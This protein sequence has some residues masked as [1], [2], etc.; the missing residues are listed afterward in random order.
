MKKRAGEIDNDNLLR[1][2]SHGSNY[3]LDIFTCI[4]DRIET[5][6]AIVEELSVA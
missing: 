1:Y 4:W 5:T 2:V 6:G 3:L